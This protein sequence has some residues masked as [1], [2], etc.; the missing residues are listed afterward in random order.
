[1]EVSLPQTKWRSIAPV[2]PVADVAASA[3]YY[4][5]KFGFAVRPVMP[6]SGDCWVILARDGLEIHLVS[7]ECP[8]GLCILVDSVDLLVE[9]LKERGAG[10]E[11]GP[12]DQ[13]YGMRDFA[14]SEPNGYKIGFWQPALPRSFWEKVFP[15][16]H[17]PIVDPNLPEEDQPF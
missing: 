15:S 13:Q 9:E 3:A 5:D 6:D 8:A 16:S 14:V 1:M 17:R 7:K 2:L 11:S 4:R 10:F 12:M